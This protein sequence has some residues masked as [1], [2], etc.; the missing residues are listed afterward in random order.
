ML[1]AFQFLIAQAEQQQTQGS[2]P[3]I[4]ALPIILILGYFLLV[5]SPMKKQEQERQK[6]LAALKRNDKVV[7]SG[8]IIGIVASIK[9]KEDEVTL[10][11]DESS[12]VRIRVLKSSIVRIVGDEE[13]GKDQKESSESTVRAGKG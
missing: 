8:G 5:R 2:N 13:P 7:T 3:I 11:V 4:F 12:N 9:E 6:L 10:K 1:F